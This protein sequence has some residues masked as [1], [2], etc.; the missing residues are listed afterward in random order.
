VGFGRAEFVFS[1]SDFR[2]IQSR[3]LIRS[4]YP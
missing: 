1:P 2:S 4:Q 3:T